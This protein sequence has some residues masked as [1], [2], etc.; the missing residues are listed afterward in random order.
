MLKCVILRKYDYKST[1]FYSLTLPS[2]VD[3]QYNT[4]KNLSEA[5]VPLICKIGAIQ[6]N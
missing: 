6:T 4:L 3:F 2:T 5:E 1:Q